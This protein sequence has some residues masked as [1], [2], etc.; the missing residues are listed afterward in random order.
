MY[1]V[2]VRQ[3]L[4]FSIPEF[5]ISR[6]ILIWSLTRYFLPSSHCVIGLLHFFFIDF[7]VY[8]VIFLSVFPIPLC[9]TFC[10]GLLL[11][12]SLFPVT[13]LCIFI[14]N[15]FITSSCVIFFFCYLSVL[16]I[17]LPLA[18]LHF[19]SHHVVILPFTN[20]FLRFSQCVA[21]CVTS[22]SFCVAFQPS[23]FSIY[24][25]FHVFLS[26]ASDTRHF[27]L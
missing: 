16:F 10:F 14:I 25:S 18:L 20:C 21:C 1:L 19:A 5:S 24:F 13:V 26:F 6:H 8:R 27:V 3:P 15:S 2:C 11:V 9:N 4:V 12:T 7:A 22:L 17:F 23:Q